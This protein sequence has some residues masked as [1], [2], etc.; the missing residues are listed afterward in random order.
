METRVAQVRVGLLILGG[1]IVVLALVWFLRGGQITRGTL[2]ET[3]FDESVQGLQVGSD[4]QYR[5]VPV[6]RVTALG[7]VSAEYGGGRD[8]AAPLYRAVYVRYLVDTAKIGHFANVSEAV[9]GG[10]RARLGTRLITGLSYIDLDFVNPTSHPVPTLPWQ[11]LAAFVPSIPSAFTQVQNAGQEVLAKL[12][13]I[14]FGALIASV[15]ELSNDLRAEIDSGD[16][17][18]TLTAAQELLATSNQAVKGADLPGLSAN[19]QRTSD[20]LQGLATNPDLAKLLKGGALATDRLAEL[21]GR[22]GA[23]ITALEG[24]VR[25]A[26]AGAANLQAGLQPILTNLSSAS[27]N[28]RELAESL[29]QY[30]AQVLSAPPPPTRG[31]LR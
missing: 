12:D 6:G 4:V 31:S 5:G 7:V 27:Q 16:L 8:T 29:R 28:L 2:F 9:Q 1:I 14:D 24:T 3:Y 23:L 18:K 11:P 25:Q 17:H 21:T 13:Q 30:P 15:T 10:L 26:Q 20:S 22:M 19:L